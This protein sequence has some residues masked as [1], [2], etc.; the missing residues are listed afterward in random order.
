MN[1]KLADRFDIELQW[2]Y[3]ILSMIID[4]EYLY[5]YLVGGM[6]KSKNLTI[7][8]CSDVVGCWMEWHECR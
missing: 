6:Y 2:A 7:V 1:Q 5:N 8:D 3:W 4:F